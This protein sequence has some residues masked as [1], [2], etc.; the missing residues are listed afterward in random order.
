MKR[1]SEMCKEI[2]DENCW[3]AVKRWN[4]KDMVRL[5]LTNI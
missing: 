3:C 1:E 5:E 4:F 2:G